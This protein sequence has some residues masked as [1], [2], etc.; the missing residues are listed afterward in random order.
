MQDVKTRKK[1][2]AIDIDIGDIGEEDEY[3]VARSHTSIRR[4]DLPPLRDAREDPDT[5]TGSIIRHR[6]SAIQPENHTGRMTS[7]PITPPLT[8]A[9]AWHVPERW[10]HV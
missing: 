4:Y 5:Q 8:K 6:R 10:R 2:A 9:P 7:K 3:Y 1:P